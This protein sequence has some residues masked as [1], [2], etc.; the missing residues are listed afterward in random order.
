MQVTLGVQPPSPPASVTITGWSAPESLPALPPGGP[1]VPAAA[2]VT[3]VVPPPP[4]LP[5][6]APGETPAQPATR[7]I[8]T[9]HR[10][11]TACPDRKGAIGLLPG[12]VCPTTV[13]G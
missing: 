4:P 7:A 5:V 10:A 11:R 8:A 6:V 12:T 2:S 3:E 13:L 9:D 1:P